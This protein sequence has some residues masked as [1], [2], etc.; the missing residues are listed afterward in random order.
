MSIDD[1]LSYSIYQLADPQFLHDS[2]HL[3]EFIFCFLVL[4][5]GIW[6]GECRVT[7]LGARPS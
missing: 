3:D 4:D 2:H 1:R 5:T 7:A 6:A